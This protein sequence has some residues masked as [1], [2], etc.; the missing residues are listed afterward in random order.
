MLF[1]SS[2]PVTSIPLASRGAYE[3]RPVT[4]LGGGENYLDFIL[5]R[6]SLSYIAD[7]VNTNSPYIKYIAYDYSTDTGA[8]IST[9]NYFELDF[10][11]PSAIYKPTGLYPIKSYSGPQTLGQN[12]PTGYEIINNGT[13]SSADILRYMGGYEQI[14]R[15]HV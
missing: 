11:Q 6:I 7:K 14:G 12:Q 13:S 9:S 10:L 15:A 2:N 8:T 4:Q 3:N 1:R 5:K